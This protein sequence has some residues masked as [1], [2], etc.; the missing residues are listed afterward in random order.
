MFWELYG[1]RTLALMKRRWWFV[2][3]STLIQIR[4]LEREK[5]SSLFELKIIKRRGMVG[6]PHQSYLSE[7]S[8]NLSKLSKI[9]V[10]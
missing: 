3:P 6:K 9:Y 2:R 8:P 5:Y 7:K 10:L 4:K 1:T